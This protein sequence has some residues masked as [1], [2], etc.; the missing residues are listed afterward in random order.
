MTSNRPEWAERLW[1]ATVARS[2][3]R[4]AAISF[5][6]SAGIEYPAKPFIAKPKRTRIESERPRGEPRPLLKPT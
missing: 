2:R 3:L 5:Y 1:L 6:R 4:M